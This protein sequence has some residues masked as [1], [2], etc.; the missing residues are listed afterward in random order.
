MHVESQICQ[1]LEAPF[2][3][4]VPQD[5]YL[6]GC[7]Q[8]FQSIRPRNLNPNS[9]I[10]F[11]YSDLTFRNSPT[12]SPLPALAPPQTNLYLVPPD[13]KTTLQH[14]QVST[15][16]LFSRFLRKSG[17]PCTMSNLP[18]SGLDPSSDQPLLSNSSHQSIRSALQLFTSHLPPTSLLKSD[19]PAQCPH[20]PRP[21]CRHPPATLWWALP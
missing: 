1:I 14:F 10:K 19:P 15:S 11:V 16:H 2:C 20:C 13:I 17:P 21:A 12:Q 8:I 9:S 5:H 3:E 6:F 7:F 4:V 18:T